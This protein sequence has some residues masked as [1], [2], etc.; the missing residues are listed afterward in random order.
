[1]KGWVLD[2]EE[3]QCADWIIKNFFEYENFNCWDMAPPKDFENHEPCE[4]LKKI[5]RN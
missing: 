5:G 3:Q 4:E 2:E 1:M